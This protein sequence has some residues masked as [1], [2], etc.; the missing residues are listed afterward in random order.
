MAKRGKMTSSHADNLGTT[1]YDE[2]DYKV[3][4]DVPYELDQHVLVQMQK[5]ERGL[6]YILDN[7]RN[8]DMTLEEV[9]AHAGYSPGYFKALSSDALSMEE[10][11]DNMPRPQARL[12]LEGFIL[13]AS[14]AGLIP[15]K[16]PRHFFWQSSNDP[17]CI[18]YR[19]WIIQNEE[20]IA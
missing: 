10:L 13:L 9:A 8:S 4:S 18:V 20:E 12:E 17:D 5:L 2:V 1:I 7:L 15:W 3:M 11:M 6:S 14:A 16:N 19:D